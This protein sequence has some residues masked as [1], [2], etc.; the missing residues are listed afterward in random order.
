MYEDNNYLAHFTYEDNNYL[1][2]YGVP[3]MKWGVKKS[4]YKSMTRAQ[5][6]EQRQKYYNTPEGKIEKAVRIGTFI[7]GPLAGVI[8]GSVMA[9]KVNNIS[10]KQVKKGKQLVDKNKNNKVKTVSNVKK[11]NETDEEAITRLKSEG[12][13][14][15]NAHH[16][17]DQ[18]GNLFMVTF[19]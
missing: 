4:V 9:S 14:G 7:G 15:S 10:G 18:N 8:A 13:I 12:K 3:G 6:K 2:H 19:D 16:V 11:K 1:A 5:K 17:F